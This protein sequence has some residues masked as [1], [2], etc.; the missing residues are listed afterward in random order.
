MSK[1]DNNPLLKGAEGML[2]K[3]MFYRTVRGK[4]QMVNR[5]K[6]RKARDT[7]P[8]QAAVQEKF[9]RAANYAK[10]HAA[11]AAEDASNTVYS[12]GITVKKHSVYLVAIS[13]YLNAPKVQF[14]EAPKYKGAVGSAI[15]IG[16]TD[17]FR[18]KSVE[19][20]ITGSDGT[21]L[22]SGDAVQT[23]PDRPELWKYTTTVANATVAGTKITATA[24]DF[25]GNKT[26]RE[27]VL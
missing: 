5:P 24:E 3:T 9:L 4:L 23:G 14:I 26:V 11:M 10:A 13:D 15:L 7:S 18:V 19:L 21:E 1:I 8:G 17:D 20:G 22:E 27:I 12:E 16:A 2:G 6:S 25:A